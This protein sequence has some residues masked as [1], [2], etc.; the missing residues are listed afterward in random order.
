MPARY[1]YKPSKALDPPL[2][3]PVIVSLY[4]FFRI[5]ARFVAIPSHLTYSPPLCGVPRTLMPIGFRMIFAQS[6]SSLKVCSCSRLVITACLITNPPRLRPTS[7]IGRSGS[8][9]SSYA[10][11][12]AK[13]SKNFYTCFSMILSRLIEESHVVGVV[14]SG[15]HSCCVHSFR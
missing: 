3:A 13:S 8:M 15:D 10:P 6:S 11:S 5:F 7:I 14:I 4:L 12:P 2:K 9:P 1:K